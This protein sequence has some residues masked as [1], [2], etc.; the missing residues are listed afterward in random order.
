ME[1]FAA[2]QRMSQKRVIPAEQD[3]LPQYKNFF[4]KQ[5]HPAMTELFSIGWMIC[6]L[7]AIVLLQRSAGEAL[8]CSNIIV[9]AGE[10]MGVHAA[11]LGRFDIEAGIVGEKTGF[12]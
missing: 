9:C 8:K 2:Y 1:C 5:N 7:H 4:A 12:G 6:F 10:K 3:L 11:L